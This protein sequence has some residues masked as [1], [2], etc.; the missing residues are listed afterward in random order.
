M[1]SLILSWVFLFGI[2][3]GAQN[4]VVSEW[5][6][7]PHLKV[8]LE[9][10]QQLTRPVIVGDLIFTADIAGTVSAYHRLHG[11]V[12]WQTR[13]EAGVNGALSYGRS[14][15]FVG[16]IQGNL[17]ALNTRDGSV[18]W[19]FKIQSE[20]LSPP[21]V[22]R[23][24]VIVSTSHDEV[25]ALSET[26]GTELWHYS[27]RGDEKMTV[28]GTAAPAIWGDQVFVGFSDGN[29]AALRLKDGKQ[30][31][32]KRLKTRERFYD[33]DTTPVADSQGVIAAAFDGKAYSLD[34]VTGTI[35]WTFPA[36]AYASPLVEE[37][38]L[39][40]SALDGHVY[41]INRKTS[42]V[43]WKSEPVEGVPLSPT[44]AG[45]YLV[46]TTSS[47]PVLVLDPKTGKRLTH[48]RLGSGTL[49][50]SVGSPDGWFY[51]FSNYNNLTS[52]RIMDFFKKKGPE[53]VSSPTAVIRDFGN[54]TSD[55]KNS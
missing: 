14:K 13:L 27:H 37:D 2:S 30:N 35:Q 39:Y 1:K 24:K 7:T 31:W 38:R 47:D 21:L 52:Y 36:G 55:R 12:L 34:L 16:D 5:V 54:S 32:I 40:L 48:E 20:W 29:L 44:R 41:A 25:Y 26:Q 18:S 6:V 11:Y 9:T 23:E 3:A 19:K 42:A 17:Y 15:L 46:V 45:D 10:P 4:E 51:C 28:R 53:T 22:F 33:V 50:A 49:A 8:S 43:I